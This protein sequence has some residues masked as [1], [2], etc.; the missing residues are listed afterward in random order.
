MMQLCSPSQKHCREHMML[1]QQHRE[2]GR[3]AGNTSNTIQAIVH[4]P[5]K[6]GQQND[7]A[8]GYLE[9]KFLYQISSQKVQKHHLRM[10]TILQMTWMRELLSQKR[11]VSGILVQILQFIS[12]EVSE[13]EEAHQRREASQAGD[14]QSSLGNILDD[15]EDKTDETGPDQSLG[16]LDWHDFPSL[17]QARARLTIESKNSAIDVFFRAR[18]TGMVGTLNLYLDLD[19]SYTWREASLIVAKAAGHGVRHARNL[20][21]W[22]HAYLKRA[23]LPVHRYGRFH[24]SI[25]DDEDLEMGIQLHLQA[26]T[27]DN[28]IWAEDIVDFIRTPDI[29]DYLGKRQTNISVRT[30]RCWLRRLD[31]RYQKKNWACTLMDMNVRMLSHTGR[32]SWNTGPSMRSGWLPMTKMG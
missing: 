30:A 31:W 12:T 29:Q 25:L 17:N 26:L 9:K 18:I 20:H 15:L 22:I 7:K 13:R 6:G 23:K 2:K 5:K 1:L 19:L 3:P 32:H 11:Q 4:E 16:K 8:F 27:K 24:S 28:Y 21:T 14:S 10:H